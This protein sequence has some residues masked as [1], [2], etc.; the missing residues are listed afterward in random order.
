M[1]ILDYYGN[2][3]RAVPLHK[4]ILTLQGFIV[5]VTI[6]ICPSEMIKGS[7]LIKRFHPSI[8]TEDLSNMDI[9]RVHHKNFFLV[10]KPYPIWKFAHFYSKTFF[11]VH[12]TGLGN[13]YTI[14]AFF[15]LQSLCL[16]IWLISDSVG[17]FTGLSIIIIW[18]KSFWLRTYGDCFRILFRNS[19]GF[20][21]F[22]TLCVTEFLWP[23]FCFLRDCVAGADPL[24]HY[25][26]VKLPI[27][28]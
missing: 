11:G 18:S 16:R 6:S 19:K 3:Y 23:S 15:L 12:E 17:P 25:D 20:F 4:L 2:D 22:I 24:Y 26:W 13:C 7:R 28:L 9:F 14:Y 5:E 10:E 1:S 8:L 27:F 21:F